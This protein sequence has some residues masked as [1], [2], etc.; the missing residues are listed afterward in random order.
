MYI[1]INIH[2]HTYIKGSI[3]KNWDTIKHTFLHLDFFT[4][5]CLNENPE[6]IQSI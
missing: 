2:I 1:L 4:Q 3:F 6:S 5:L